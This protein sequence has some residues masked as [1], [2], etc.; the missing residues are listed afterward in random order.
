MKILKLKSILFSLM[1]IG[2]VTIFLTSCEKTNIHNSNV[3]EIKDQISLNVNDLP[4][5]EITLNDD[6][7]NSLILK[8]STEDKALLAL[9]TDEVLKAEFGKVDSENYIKSSNNERSLVN[10]DKHL[11]HDESEPGIN[12]FFEVIETTLLRSNLTFSISSDVESQVVLR[13]Y[14]IH[15]WYKSDYNRGFSGLIVKCT[16]RGIDGLSAYGYDSPDGY[17]NPNACNYIE[18]PHFSSKYFY[19]QNTSE[20][21]FER[22]HGRCLWVKTVGFHNDSVRYWN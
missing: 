1:A 6:S 15:R 5:K 22:M 7:G 10:S 21:Y 18:T 11:L 20:K 16:R 19:N 12:V 9:Y 14:N 8:V 3:P 4:S 2:V 13:S 17:L